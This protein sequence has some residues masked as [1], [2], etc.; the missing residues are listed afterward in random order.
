MEKQGEP[1]L[2]EYIF[3]DRLKETTLGQVIL[4]L[5]VQF[6]AGNYYYF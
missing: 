1:G 5:K 6:N 3:V 4:E 2:L